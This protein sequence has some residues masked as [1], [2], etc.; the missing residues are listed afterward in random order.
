M[1]HYDPDQITIIFA[2]IRMSGYADGEFV[3]V[4]PASQDFTSKA[5]TDGEVTRSKTNDRRATITIILEQTSPVNAQLS[6]LRKTDLN[7]PNGAGVGAFLMRDRNN[8]NTLYKAQNAWIQ[9]PPSSSF[10]RESGPREWVIEVDK[11]DQFIAG[12]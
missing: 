11:L 5:G 7:A 1:H 10:G 3:R 4:E 2:G 9:G 6:A 12:N 8:G